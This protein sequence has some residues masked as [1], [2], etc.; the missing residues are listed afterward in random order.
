VDVVQTPQSKHPWTWCKRHRAS[1][2]GRDANATELASYLCLVSALCLA[3][4]RGVALCHLMCP[5]DVSRRDLAVQQHE[6][7]ACFSFSRVLCWRL[8]PW[9]RLPDSLA[10]FMPSL[11]MPLPASPDVASSSSNCKAATVGGPLRRRPCP[12]RVGLCIHVAE[13]ALIEQSAARFR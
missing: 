7:C 3:I 5:C 12:T 8:L 1:I 4:C 9:G 10:W 2:R 11:M 6:S 13:L